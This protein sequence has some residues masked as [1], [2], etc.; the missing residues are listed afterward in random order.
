M[1][2]N[3]K[4]GWTFYSHLGILTRYPAELNITWRTLGKD[5]ITNKRFGQ[6]QMSGKD[7]L[8]RLKQNYSLNVFERLNSRLK[9]TYLSK[10]SSLIYKMDIFDD[11][12]FPQPFPPDKFLR[13]PN[14]S[15]DQA[16]LMLGTKATGKSCLIIISHKQLINTYMKTTLNK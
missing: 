3:K 10:R 13:L 11:Y 2:S 5:P 1:Y 16:Y 6:V 8:S 4:I 7:I 15:P 12:S 14:G 9:T